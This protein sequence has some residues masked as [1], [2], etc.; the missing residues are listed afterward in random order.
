MDA[1]ISQ[2]IAMIDSAIIV[3]RQW[4]LEA[5]TRQEES[6]RQANLDELQ[7]NLVAEQAALDAL[8]SEQ[9]TTAPSQ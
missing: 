1:A 3:A 8:R 2:R 9:T 7:A 4:L 5:T 6:D